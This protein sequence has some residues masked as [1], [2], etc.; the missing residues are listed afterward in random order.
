MTTSG[1]IAIDRVQAVVLVNKGNMMQG[2]MDEV[3]A[4]CMRMRA[5][6]NAVELAQEASRDTK[7]CTDLAVVLEVVV[8][9][10]RKR[11]RAHGAP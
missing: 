8:A 5:M 11:L 2:T 3:R 9:H 4:E 7:E 1:T 6:L 10:L